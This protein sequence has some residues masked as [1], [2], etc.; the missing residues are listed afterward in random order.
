ML[1]IQ[2]LFPEAHLLSAWRGQLLSNHFPWNR[3]MSRHLLENILEFQAVSLE[4]FFFFIII[5]SSTSGSLLWK[6]SC[7]F[8]GGQGLALWFQVGTGGKSSLCPQEQKAFWRMV[9]SQ[10]KNENSKISTRVAPK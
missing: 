2:Q 3:F 8:L 9:C 5:L 4:F 1:C 6:M 10:V 7:P